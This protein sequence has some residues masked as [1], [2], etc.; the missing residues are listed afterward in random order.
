[1]KVCVIGNW[2]SNSLYSKNKERFD[3]I[4][5][6]N[7]PQHNFKWDVISIIDPQPVRIIKEKKHDLGLIWCPPDTHKTATAQRLPGIWKPVYKRKP[8]YNSGLL[9][10]D[11]VCQKYEDLK[12]IH[13]WGFNSLYE[14]N[15]YS[16][17]DNLVP[18]KR[19]RN[20]NKYWIPKWKEVISNYKNVKFYTHIPSDQSLKK[21]YKGYENFKSYYHSIQ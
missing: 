17:M 7:I 6:C 12:E 19:T 5:C 14:D 15:F 11:Y 2:T 21:E 3:L 1:M 18:R 13:L 8:W 20:L 16:Q 9:S 4:I 10:V